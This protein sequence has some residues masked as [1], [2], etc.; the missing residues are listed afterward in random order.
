MPTILIKKSDTPGAAPTGS[1][2]TNLAGGAEI[3]VNTAD[4][5]VFSMNSSS[6]IIEL[7]TNPGSLTTADASATVLRSGSATITDLIA[8]SASITTLTATS[9]S[10]TNLTATSLVLSNL[11]IASAN[12]TT[13]TSSSATITNLIATSASIT[14]LTNNPT[15]GAGTANGVLYLNGSKEATSG[16]GLVFDGSN[17]GVSTSSP[18]TRVHAVQAVN[19]QLRVAY[20]ATNYMDVGYF[21][22]N[23]VAPSNPFTA[24]FLN[25]SE[26]M[27][28]TSTG[29]GIGTSSPASKL[30]VVTGTARWRISNDGSGNIVDEILDSTGAS[31]RDYKLY[32]SNLISYASGIESMRIT[33]AGNVGI[34]T[35]SPGG[36]LDVY[37]SIYKR[38]LLTYPS[39]YVTRMQLSSFGYI[40]ADAGNDYYKI[41]AGTAAGSNIRFETSG[42]ER[43]RIDPL[44]NVGIGTSSPGAPLNVKKN[45]AGAV[46]EMLRL[47]N[48]GPGAGSMS[49]INFDASGTSYGAITG[50][51]GSG[52]PQMK[53][54]L[55]SSTAGSWDWIYQSTTLATL[56][57]SGNL[58]IGTSS[59]TQKLDVD[60]GATNGVVARFGRSSGQFAYI[61]AD[62]N[63]VYLSSDS[64]GNT[65]WEFNETSDY[66]AA[67]TGGTERLRLASG[68]LGLGVT[69]SAWRSTEKAIQIG[70]W[71]GLYTD[72]GLTTEISY[73]QY[74]NS[75]NQR[76]YQNT[77]YASR[78]QQ[79]LG[80]HIWFTA[81]SG[82]AGN[83][84]SFTTV[85][86][87]D[88]SGNLLVGATSAAGTERLN[89]VGGIGI[90]INEDGLG[91]KVLSLRSDFAGAGPA[92][93]VSTNH[94]LLLQTNNTERARISAG[95]Y[96]KAS[97]TGSYEGSASSYHELRTNT[98]DEFIA[99][100]TTTASSLPYGFIIKYTA[101][102]PNNATDSVFWTCADSSA[103]RATIRS[104]GGLA[105][106][107]SN[108]TDLSD[109]RTKKDIT[110]APSYWDKIG[111]LE[112]VTYKYNDQ[113]HDDVN[114]GVI[115]QQVEAVEPVWVDTDGF[116]ETPEGEEP[117]KTVYTK[118]I[119]FAAIKA[120]QEAMTRIEEL[121]AKVA[122]LEAK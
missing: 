110:P 53:F 17:L 120:L 55:P 96:F 29:L 16:S 97:N 111:A 85:M 84:V 87:L 40:E 1:D 33:S 73:N 52:G 83:Q 61:Y 60:R 79:Y 101:A 57:T 5:R 10:V 114:V 65:S 71:M 6:A 45:S 62:T 64:S 36:Q 3:A 8:T 117:L 39:I 92:V 70:S 49:K 112:I 94:P 115:A 88:A 2:L 22:T 75:S 11:S 12:V 59:P 109:E 78:Y 56:L 21:G 102:A 15:F 7:G 25:G 42:T 14:T 108:N 76:I 98:S 122:A 30:D 9:A 20:D 50:G 116:G 72:S 34:G 23:T 81:G 35:S 31:Y 63:S 99:R 51:Y 26:A 28:L 82:T 107:Q 100:F 32:G 104:N 46:V 47:T 93:N 37:T 121:E 67:W 119:T 66:L 13:L 44:G 18:A 80:E 48:D 103:T 41:N 69:P 113:T 91:T 43:M 106:Y 90:R 24:Y 68:N 118:D 54:E 58:G 19:Y 86:K 89:V 74:I 27:R 4:K 95:G 105:N 77:G 38:L